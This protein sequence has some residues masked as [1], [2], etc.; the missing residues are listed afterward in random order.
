[1]NIDTSLSE[2]QNNQN[3]VIK[4]DVIT[5]N[6]SIINGNDYD[7]SHLLRISEQIEATSKFNHI[8]VVRLLNEYPEI[9]LTEN[10]Y[11]V[12]IN[13]TNVPNHVIEKLDMFIN[14]VQRQ[15][16]L[17]SDVERQ[18]EEFKNIYFTKDNKEIV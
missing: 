4:N 13:L 18:K 9:T 6:A 7:V 2:K 12:H 10:K 1:M 5:N 8:E 3:D 16:K 17:L 11:G 14:H 15:E